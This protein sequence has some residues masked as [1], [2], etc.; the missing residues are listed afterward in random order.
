MVGASPLR[1]VT[2]R[3]AKIAAVDSEERTLAGRV[4]GALYC[5]GG[6]TLTSFLVLPG[7]S[8]SHPGWIAGIAAGATAWG[9]CSL[10]LIRWQRAPWW[11]IQAST[12][13]AFGLI[14]GLIASTGGAHSPGWVYL[15]F[16]AIFAS[17]FD[18]PPV[19]AFYLLGCGAT[20]A[21]PVLYDSHFASGGFV[22]QLSI[23]APAYFVFGATVILG[24]ALMWRLRAQAE[25][26]AS[27][28]G[29]FHPP[30]SP[31]GR[32]GYGSSIVAPVLVAGRTWGFLAATKPGV[33]GIT[34]EDEQRMM[35]FGDLL[36]TA[37]ASIEDRAKLAAQAS[38][39]PLTGLANHRTLQQR[40]SAEV[41]RTVRHSRSLS[42]ALVDI[43]NF[44]QINDIAGHEAGDVMLQS[45][46]DSLTRLARAEDTLG[47]VGGDEFAWLLPETTREEALV[48][49][50]RAR[51]AIADSVPPPYRLTVSAGICDTR[52]TT[53]PAELIHFADGA[54]YWSK[55]HGRDQCW[56]YDPAVV[57]ELS[58]QERAERLARSQ[59]LLGMRALARA[60][61]AKD[62]AT[63]EHSD[64]VS[65]LSFRLARS[66]GWP[67]DRARL[68][69][70]AALVHDVGKIGVSDAILRKLAPLTREEMTQVKEHAELSAR[71][72]EGVLAAEQVEWIRMHHERPDGA[73][74]PHGLLAAQIPEGASLLALADAWD[75][76]TTSRPY[77]L[78]KPLEDALEECVR[79][80]GTQFTDA[81]VDAL[82]SL[83]SVGELASAAVPD[84]DP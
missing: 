77:S 54:L 29:S 35:E 47:R 80:R 40:L 4:S 36:A 73:G 67:E 14:A 52:T 63:R 53:D 51:R 81:A 32:L 50:E 24:K 75:V 5:V 78:P 26:L 71:I 49:V 82:L 27:E 43:D 28:Q 42:V 10:W 84:A 38:T 58:A 31:V 64:R 60:I 44:K 57:N 12:I 25:R 11:V 69:S 30:D 65:E 2:G 13:A 16:V 66:A 3:L 37:I 83:Y 34:T 22:A 59:A 8:R 7:V 74:Y 61:D 72:V 46:A 23:A 18:R 9:A 17:Y 48:A 68:L 62:P 39:D 41:S 20:Q 1:A 21:L 55:A 33:L 70:E 56:I 79:G 6:I 45:V 19:A 76:M 15:F